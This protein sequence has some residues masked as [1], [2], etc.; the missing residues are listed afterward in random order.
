MMW[1]KFENIGKVIKIFR[2]KTAVLTI[3]LWLLK[4]QSTFE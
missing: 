4:T 1:N 3:N 2:I